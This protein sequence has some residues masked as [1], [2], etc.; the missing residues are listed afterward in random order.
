MHNFEEFSAI[1]AALDANSPLRVILELM[2]T[3]RHLSKNPNDAKISVELSKQRDKIRQHLFELGIIDNLRG[4][5]SV[6]VSNGLLKI[7]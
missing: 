5:D 1:L 4:F 6:F 7:D 3:R 2:E